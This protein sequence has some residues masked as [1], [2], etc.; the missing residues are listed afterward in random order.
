MVTRV[1]VDGRVAALVG[2]EQVVPV[3][4]PLARMV[5]TWPAPMFALLAAAVVVALTPVHKPMVV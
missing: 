2:A 4:A 1:L 5:G 3:G